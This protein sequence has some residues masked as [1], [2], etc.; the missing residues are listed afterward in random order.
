VRTVKDSVVNLLVFLLVFVATAAVFL[1]TYGL[2]LVLVPG[3]K[4]LIFSSPYAASL[5]PGL[6]VALAFAQFRAVRRPGR[7]PV[8]WVLLAGAFFLLLS[9]S[10]PVIQQLAPVRAADATPLLPHRFLPLAD[11]SQLLTSGHATVLVPEGSGTMSV[12]ADT[13]FDPLN[14]R[15]VFT[16]GDPKELGATGPERAYYQYTPALASVQTDLLALYSVLRD[17]WSDHPFLFWFQAWAVTWL[18]LGLFFFFSLR[19]WPLV[20]VVLVLVLMRLCLVFLTYAFWSVPALVDLWSPVAVASWLRTWAP[21]LLI[22]A[23]A[24]SLFFMMWLAKPWRRE[25]LT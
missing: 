20:H 5:L 13:Q 10:I 14:Q 11:G 9:L 6:L 16:S 4:G 21:I 22:N 17:S 25:A 15:F 23:A 7:F 1:A 3:G 19:T 2:A 8:T 12:S 24:A 18:F